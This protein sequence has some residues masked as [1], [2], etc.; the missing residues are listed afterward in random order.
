[1]ATSISRSELGAFD[2]AGGGQAEGT[3]TP[4][5]QA[6]DRTVELAQILASAQAELDEMPP[7]VIRDAAAHIT[8]EHYGAVDSGTNPEA[9]GDLAAGKD[10][11]Q[12]R[13]RPEERADIMIAA[14]SAVAAAGVQPPT[15]H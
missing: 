3:R 14:H 8:R 5:E 4:H 13:L 11:L 15:M 6:V 2:I 10:L 7:E 9:T 1:M 12:A